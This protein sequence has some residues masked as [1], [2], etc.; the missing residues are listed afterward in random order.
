MDIDEIVMVKQGYL[1]LWFQ[2]ASGE[3][4]YQNKLRRFMRQQ[5]LEERNGFKQGCGKEEKEWS[6]DVLA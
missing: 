1:S 3:W 4:F 2:V 6:D 5:K